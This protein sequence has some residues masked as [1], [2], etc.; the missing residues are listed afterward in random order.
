MVSV[1]HFSSQSVLIL[2]Q[3]GCKVLAPI[4][5]SPQVEPNGNQGQGSLQ[6]APG[7]QYTKRAKVIPSVGS[8]G[9]L[10]VL[11]GSIVGCPVSALAQVVPDNT[12]P[13]NSSV[14]E[15]CESCTI[16]GGT[17][18]NGQWLHSFSQFSVP[19]GSEVFFNNTDPSIVR[20]IARVTGGAPSQING[21]LRANGAA[22]LILLNPSGVIVGP[23]STLQLGGSFS[24]STASSILLADGREFSAVNPSLAPLLRV[25]TPIGLQTGLPQTS[26][27]ELADR[28]LT[29]STQ[30]NL[31]HSLALATARFNGN[32]PGLD[33]SQAR[34]FLPIQ[35]ANP[36]TAMAIT[37]ERSRGQGLVVSGQGGVPQDSGQLLRS[38]SIWH[39]FRRVETQQSNRSSS[40]SLQATPITSRTLPRSPIVEAQGWLQD[41]QGRI[42]LIA[43]PP[44]TT[45]SALGLALA[46]CRS[47]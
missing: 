28:T 5:I 24:A 13:I 44:Q 10:L 45:P 17:V 18:S 32:P 20:I 38:S 30:S 4:G 25:S 26:G 6:R 22:N 36:T 47:F 40:S 33:V 9:I 34:V 42:A 1:A 12:L 14:P 21:S 31:D 41:A 3:V 8:L 11:G 39:D 23:N 37:C 7:S 27:V 16:S 19:A 2:P 46:D 35:F 43:Q 15:G 29:G